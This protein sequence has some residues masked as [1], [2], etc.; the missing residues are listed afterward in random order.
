M[1]LPRSLGWRLSFVLAALAFICV[2]IA[3]SLMALLNSPSREEGVPPVLVV[4]LSSLGAAILVGAV[5]YL[6]GSGIST[7]ILRVTD[8]ARRLAQGDLGHRLPASPQSETRDL[9]ATL[10]TMADALRANIQDLAAERNKLTAILESMADGV[11][12]ID[13]EGRIVHMNQVAGDLLSFDPSVVL[14]RRFIEVARNVEM[15]QLV[16]RSTESG[17]AR[18]EELQ[19]SAGRYVSVIAIPLREGGSS[20]AGVILTLHDLTRLRQV[21][22]TRREFVSNVSHEF[23]S[24]LASIKAAVETLE[25]GALDEAEAAKDFVGRIHKDTNRLISLADNL[26]EL[27]KLESGQLPQELHPVTLAPLLQEIRDSFYSNAQAKDISIVVEAHDHLPAVTAH[28]DYL[29]QVLVNLL[30]NA[31]KFTPAGGEIN[32]HAGIRDSMVEVRVR[33]TGPG[34]PREHLPHVFERFY[35]VDRSR[36]DRGVG[37]GLAIVKHIV[38]HQGGEVGVESV[39]GQGASFSF[40][41]PRAN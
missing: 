21:D 7:S 9:A 25:D 10:N 39:E 2:A 6:L 8:G 23:R 38:Q 12:M 11:I 5:A 3:S 17:E 18:H 13:A 30:D 26:L 1:R 19:V 4:A 20:S 24:P 28:E 36:H 14:E 15:H 35:K 16:A 37:L 40:T 31:V 22:V 32:V 34:I 33:N 27:S 41:I 29:R